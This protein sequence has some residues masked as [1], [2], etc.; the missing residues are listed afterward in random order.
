VMKIILSPMLLP[1]SIG[2]WE[3]DSPSCQADPGPHS[4]HLV[5]L[6]MRRLNT[7]S[8]PYVCIAWC[9]DHTSGQL[10]LILPT[11]SHLTT[12][13]PF[14]FALASGQLKRSELCYCLLAVGCLCRL[15]WGSFTAIRLLYYWFC[16]CYCDENESGQPW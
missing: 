8:S 15:R 7:S 1:W 11:P 14:H 9:F 10:Y 2:L 4:G 3:L 12:D 13:F 6:F 16:V 5:A